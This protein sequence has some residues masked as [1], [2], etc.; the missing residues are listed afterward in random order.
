[1]LISLVMFICYCSFFVFGVLFCNL[2]IILM[3]YFIVCLLAFSFLVLVFYK[4]FLV[5]FAYPRRG[6]LGVATLIRSL[7]LNPGRTDVPGEIWAS[8][9]PG[10]VFTL[11]RHV[12]R[13]RI[14]AR[15]V[16]E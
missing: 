8:R 14:R 1:M 11:R 16:S 7:K 13:K 4:D 3:C 10:D 5:W 15:K 9:K 12:M 6:R 2:V